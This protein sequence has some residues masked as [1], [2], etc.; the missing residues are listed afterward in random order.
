[1]VFPNQPDIVRPFSSKPAIQ[2]A[3]VKHE[4]IQPRRDQLLILNRAACHF[5]SSKLKDH[6]AL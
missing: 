5:W 4:I 1:M 2:I 3:M 6:N